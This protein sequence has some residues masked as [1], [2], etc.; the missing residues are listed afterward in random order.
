MIG[1]FEEVE[2]DPELLARFARIFSSPA[3]DLLGGEVLAMDGRRGRAMIRF[4]PRPEFCNPLG[5]VQGGFLTAM[6]DSTAAIAAIALSGVTLFMPTVE[7]KTSFIAPA[8]CAPLVG[9]G[10]CLHLGR[11]TAFLEGSLHLE[12]DGRLLAHATATARPIAV[13]RV[14]ESAGDVRPS[15]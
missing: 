7:I 8:P 4:R 3:F 13:E 10:R 5:G 14:R 12:E 9:I 11:R 15:Q 1:M 6:L 2:G